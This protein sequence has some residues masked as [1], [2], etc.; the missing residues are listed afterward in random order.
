MMW[1]RGGMSLL[2][3]SGSVRWVCDGCAMGVR[4]GDTAAPGI[5]ELQ[6][7]Q[8][9]GRSI[10]IATLSSLVALC[11][12]GWIRAGAPGAVSNVGLDRVVVRP[13]G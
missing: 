12:V 8:A 2:P 3:W 9:L 13:I 1:S 5:T 6:R 4:E 11:L 7:R 10:D